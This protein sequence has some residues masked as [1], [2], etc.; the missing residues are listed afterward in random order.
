MNLMDLKKTLYDNNVP[1]RWYSLNEGL[2]PD[3]CILFKNYSV[4]EFFYL[5]EKGYR[6]DH[7]SFIN[8]SDAFEYL[9]QKMKRQL[10]LFKIPPRNAYDDE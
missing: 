8:D 2:K 1:D 4:W 5:D 9:W 7:K 6:H 3:A 10:D